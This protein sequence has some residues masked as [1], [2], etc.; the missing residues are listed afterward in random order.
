[1]TLSRSS[2]KAQ[3]VVPSS[4]KARV[5]LVDGV[6]LP[7][8]IAEG[9]LSWTVDDGGRIVALTCSDQ[10]VE[11]HPI[12]VGVAHVTATGYEGGGSR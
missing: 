5:A 8:G 9:R 3:P 1:M 11:A 6:G 7:G 2:F 12:A 4:G 10:F